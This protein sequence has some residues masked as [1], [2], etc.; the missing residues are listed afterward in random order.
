MAVMD[1]RP[2]CVH[3]NQTKWR[4]MEPFLNVKLGN[5]FVV[6]FDSKKS[7][8]ESQLSTVGAKMIPP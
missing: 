3:L 5:F 8:W 1:F 6:S 7:E 2:S 4:K